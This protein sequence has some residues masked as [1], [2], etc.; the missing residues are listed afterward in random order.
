[1]KWQ[2]QNKNPQH[3]TSQLKK[4]RNIPLWC[5]PGAPGN[6]NSTLLIALTVSQK[7]NSETEVLFDTR[8]TQVTEVTRPHS[9]N[10]TE[11]YPV[12][13]HMESVRGSPTRHHMETARRNPL[14][15]NSD[16]AQSTCIDLRVQGEPELS[17]DDE[18][19]KRSLMNS[20][21]KHFLAF[22]NKDKLMAELF[23][24]SDDKEY[25]G[26]AQDAKDTDKEQGKLEAHEILLITDTVQP[27]L[28]NV[29]ATLGHILQMCTYTC[30]SK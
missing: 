20:L 25:Q 11:E 6:S 22:P 18:G 30:W 14:R 4:H 1:M 26:I 23:P 24:N 16:Q 8:P 12:H 28:C 9:S 27:K 3:T 29:Y 10:G 17:T 5:T 7:K 2:K 13:L 15:D 19:R 21:M